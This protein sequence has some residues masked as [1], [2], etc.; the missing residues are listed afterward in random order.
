MTKALHKKKSW[1]RRFLFAAVLVLGLAAALSLSILATD[2]TEGI[3]LRY[4]DRYDVTGKTVEILDAGEPTSYLVGYGVEEGTPDAAVVTLEGDTLIATGIGTA[5][6]RIDGEV[7][8]VTVKKAKVNIVVIMGQSNAGNHFANAT[9]DVTCPAGTA[10]W[11]G[12]GQGTA[13]TAPVDYTQPS[14]GFHT[15]LLAELYAQSVAAGDPVKNVMV[16]QEGITS[17]NGQS[18]TKWAASETDTSGT[19]GTATMLRNCISYYEQNSALYEIEN[20]GVYWLQGE[21]DVAMAP[22]AYTKLFL[23]MWGD[24]KDAGAEYMAFFRVRKGVNLNGEDHEDLSYTGSL[25]AQ[26][27]MVNTYPDMYMATTITE[28]WTGTATAEHSVDISRYITLMEQY[29]QTESHND[30][31]GNA[32]TVKNGILTTSMKTLYGSN[33]KCHYGKFGYAII[34]ADAAYHMYHALHGEQAA[35][36]QGDTSGKADAETLRPLGKTA[37][38]NIESMTENL[39]FRPACG[40]AAGTLKLQVK[41]GDLDVTHHVIATDVNT[42]GTV[43]TSL[44]RELDDVTITATYTPVHGTPGSVTYTVVDHTH[45]Y[46]DGVCTACGAKHPNAEDFGGK[47]V[48]ILSHSASTYAGVSNNTDDNSTIGNNDVYYTEG[49]HGV[50]LKDTW[51]Q[52]AADALDMQLLVNNSWSGSC[53]LA[54]RKGAASVAYGDRAINLHNDRTGEEPDVIWVYI[55]C[56]DF[57]YYKDTFGK[58]A[59]VDLDALIISRGDGTFTYATPTTTCEAYAIMLHKITQRYPDAQI[60]CMTSTARR[61]IDYTGDSYPDAGQPTEYSAQLQQIANAFGFPIV[62]LEQ[63]IPKEVELFDRYMGDKRAHPNALGMDQI[64]N[65]LLSVML[66]QEAQICHVT[67]KSG[68]V[69]EQAVLLGRSYR[70]T[71]SL[72]EGE[73]LT[74]TMGGKDV[75]DQCCV[76]GEIQIASVTGDVSVEIRRAPKS[77]RWE[78]DGNAFASLSANG[79]SDNAVT[80]EQGSIADGV[81]TNVIASLAEQIYLYHDQ[82]WTVEWAVSGNWDATLLASSSA[83]KVTDSAFLFRSSTD[84]GLLALGSYDGTQYNN[85]GIPTKDLALDLTA[86]HVYRLENRI[87]G[88]GNMVYLYIDGKEIGPMNQY[89]IGSKQDTN[90]TSDWVSGRDFAFGY[91]GT[92]TR[93]INNC[94]LEYFSVWEAGHTHTYVGGVCTACGAK[95]RIR[96]R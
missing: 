51:W 77:F 69:K 38:I 7:Y 70:A 36:V 62:D 25:A 43:D 88:Q 13:A 73:R 30:S 22:E 11:W 10:Y 87:D 5:S 4:D 82:P 86:R 89:Y 64:T 14:M 19:D 53:V 3:E 31:Y 40:S 79:F 58:A 94:K 80:L 96:A 95:H 93:A 59:D 33:N 15:P 39:T 24:L 17:K 16:W 50:Y 49:K 37:V 92:T 54:P 55:G 42:F 45:T 34:G 66:G 52:Q 60:Y 29:G 44:L 56:N 48:S 27:H 75:T 6:V 35:I 78:L 23:A 90:T 47:K 32:A 8:E 26:I 12:N 41:S 63:A 1:G 65:E 18:I 71:V 28:N 76:G 68:A 84:H 74:V 72:K 21:S 91:M 83:I 46:V 2:G 20:C 61:E 9:S 81:F 57:A 67:T 85:Y